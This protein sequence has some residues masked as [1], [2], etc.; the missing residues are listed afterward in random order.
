MTRTST[1]IAALASTAL[2]GTF[3]FASTAYAG[4]PRPGPETTGASLPPA[5]STISADVKADLV[6]MVQE[7]RLAEDV[8]TH[9]ADKYDVSRP[10]TN[11]ARAERQHQDAV[12]VLLNRYGLADPSAG[13]PPGAYAADDLQALYDRLITQADISLEEAYRVGVAIET[14]DIADLKEALA[15]DGLPAD[16][17]VVYERLIAGSENH[18]KAFARAAGGGVVGNQDGTGL[19]NGR[20][21]VDRGRGQGVGRQGGG[22][23]R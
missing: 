7:E 20:G 10:F 23:N 13:M 22:R 1:T 9:I 17:K 6:F 4:G 21:N 15:E 16:A 8:Y 18:L 2:V 19:Q 5:A 14:T 12:S 3:G 11:I